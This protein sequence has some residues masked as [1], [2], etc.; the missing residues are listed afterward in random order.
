M[1]SKKLVLIDGSSYFYRAFHAL[2]PLTNSKGQPTGAVY[3]VLNMIR[4][5][6]KDEQPDYIAVVFDTPGKTFRDALYPD[7]KATR[8]P[9]P[10]EL[11]VQYQPLIDTLTAMGIPLLAVEGVEADDVIGTLAKQA[12]VLGLTTLISTGDKDF[13][14][15]VDEQVTLV[16]TMS[17]QRYDIQAV[18]EKFG[19]GPELIIDYLALIGDKVDNVPGVD[20]VGP[21]TAVKWLEQYGNLQAILDNAEEFKGKVGENLRASL[22][23]LPLSKQL[24]TIKTDCELTLTPLQL[25]KREP[26][27]E[28]LQKAF[29]ELEFKTWLDELLKQNPTLS[30]EQHHYETILTDTDL[31]RWIEKIKKKGTFA[32]DT[33]TTSLDYMNARLVG[34]SFAVEAGHA[35]YV[36]FGHDYPEAPTQLSESQVL[37]ALQPLLE[38]SH[39]KK[40][41][42]HMKYD[43]NVLRQY[44]IELQGLMFDTMLESYILNSAASRHDLESLALK[45]LGRNTIAFETVAG[46]G[47]K[48]K[49]FNEV[50]LEP[51][52]EYAAEDADITLQLHQ[53]LWPQIQEQ[54]SL[55]TVFET[56]ELP[57]VQV[58]SH[59]ETTGV[60]IDTE[61]LRTQSQELSNQLDT[62]QHEIFSIAG[63]EFNI[64]SP[65]QLQEILFDKLQLPCTQKTPTGQPSTAESVLEELAHDYPMPRLIL[66]YRSVSKLKS[67][68]TDALPQQINARTGRVHTS[69][70]QAVTATG[71]LSSTHPNLQNIPVRTAEGRR[72]RQA[73]IAAPGHQLI[74]SDYSQIELRIMA[75]LSDDPALLKAFANGDDI[76][77]AT[78]AEVLGVPMSEVT[79]DQRRSAKAIN[80]GLIYGMSAFGLA[81][82]IGCDRTTA[83]AYMDTYFHR[84]P[85]VKQYMETTRQK[86]HHQGYVET[87]FGRR[88]YL[89]EINTRNMMRQRAA[90]RAA[91]NAPLQGSAADIIKLAMIKLFN[92]LEKN[93]PRAKLIMQVHD[94]LV[95]EVPNEEVASV[96]ATIQDVMTHVV[97]L[98]V[99]MSVAIGAGLNW[100]EAH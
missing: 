84:Y 26:D 18:K 68:Y 72:I 34:V 89:P 8:S 15:L 62:L 56:I 39:L 50:T 35:A 80:F 81:R 17:N 91:I 5:L 67:T 12:T 71:R 92:E 9:T 10:D 100:D 38:D 25:I 53:N 79:D 23:Y 11:S 20:N 83:Q 44:D 57:L 31:Q 54:A 13:A 24:V 77:R 14:Q 21:K 99:P 52:A 75:H 64:S 93:H 45:Y 82:Q 63:T 90:E 65:K 27:R 48:Q 78:A 33:E 69:Y 32:F 55:Q 96:T 74:S 7:Y 76:H 6:Q 47:A 85:G 51:A 58:L 86:A 37:T 29:S 42:Q 46:K 88:L 41:G 70:N 61:R 94:E 16:N 87:I 1:Q 4:K 60:L 98:K 28:A 30:T 95:C 49:T 66:D 36:P 73:F 43:M 40:I 59:M 22:H 3:G 2:P 97:T 19:V